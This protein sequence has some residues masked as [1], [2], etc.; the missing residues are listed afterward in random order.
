[1]F[2]LFHI[3][4]CNW[5]LYPFLTEEDRPWEIV[6]QALYLDAKDDI[7][8]VYTKN[9]IPPGILVTIYPYDKEMKASHW[10]NLKLND[11]RVK[12]SRNYLLEREV[13]PRVVKDKKSG[14][15]VKEKGGKYVFYP[16]A[17]TPVPPFG[18]LINHCKR[19][20]N[21]KVS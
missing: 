16:S 1:M 5:L 19:H 13:N 3:Y 20:P 4:V 8:G 12:D 15:E 18:H 2:S 11:D 14:K 7:R 9:K 6:E 10:S 21:L 17:K